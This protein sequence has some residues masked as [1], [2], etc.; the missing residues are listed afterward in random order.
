[1]WKKRPIHVSN[2]S[3]VPID[4]MNVVLKSTKEVLKITEVDL[5]VKFFGSFNLGSGDF[6]SANWYIR[7]SWNPERN[8]ADADRILNRMMSEP[9]RKREPHYDVFIT[10]RDLYDGSRQDNRFMFGLTAPHIGTVQS[11]HRFEKFQFS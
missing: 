8:Q 5:P 9:Y 1:M 7:S 10:G 11:Y 3:E 6:E 4:Y 2:T